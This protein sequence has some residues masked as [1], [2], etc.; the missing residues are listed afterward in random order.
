MSHR[1]YFLILSALFFVEFLILAISPY[2]RSDWALENVM[3]LVVVLI[4]GST[5]KTFPFSRIS[6]SLIFVFMCLHE[7][8]AHYTYARVPYDEF[9]TVH[10]NFSLNELM[11]WERNHYDRAVHFL[12]GLLLTYPFKEVYCRITNGKGFWSYFF[13]FLFSVNASMTF[14][15]LEWAAVEVFGGELGMA[16]LG[17]QGDIWDAH[18]DMALAAL[19][20]LITIVMVAGFNLRLNK[21]FFKDWNRSLRIKR[22][23]PMGEDEIVRLLEEQDKK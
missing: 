15:L 20:A 14:E 12:Y 21:N 16:F 4:L 11:G 8:G 3:T 6:Y 18:K 19:G 7:I 23:K 13:P 9:L 1:R 5:Y 17:T 2:N 10:F 22:R